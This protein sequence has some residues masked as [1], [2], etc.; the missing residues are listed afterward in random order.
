MFFIFIAA[1]IY[2][3]LTFFLST[4]LLLLSVP[5]FLGLVY[6]VPPIMNISFQKWGIKGKKL[7]S[8]LLLPSLATIFYLGFAYLVMSSGLWEQFVQLHTQSDSQMSIEI[9]YNLLD[10]TQLIFVGLVYY[11]SSL[12]YYLLEKRKENIENKGVQH[13]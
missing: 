2:L 1:T 12:G 8:S 7:L 9:A 4:N 6:L 5:V 13:A 3:A 11:G 10:N